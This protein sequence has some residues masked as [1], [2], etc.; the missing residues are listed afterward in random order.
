MPR[1]NIDNTKVHKEQSITVPLIP[2]V[3]I[4]DGARSLNLMII[5]SE[6]SVI[7]WKLGLAV[8]SFKFCN[9]LLERTIVLGL[10]IDTCG[11]GIIKR[12]FEYEPAEISECFA[13]ISQNLFFTTHVV[14]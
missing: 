11:A 2:T 1:T 9:N 8:K 13:F 5:A 12:A 14:C 7:Y 3:S 10:R 4:C 6:D